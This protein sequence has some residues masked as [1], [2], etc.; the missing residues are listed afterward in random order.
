MLFLDGIYVVTPTPGN[1]PRFH[2]VFAPNSPYRARLPAAL[3]PA[4]S[5][6]ARARSARWPGK[7]CFTRLDWLGQG[8]FRQNLGF[9]A[10][11]DFGNDVEG[12][13]VA[14]EPGLE[15]RSVR[16]WVEAA[17]R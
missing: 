4:R 1:R 5:G 15:C 9:G 12:H 7:R 8:E 3:H 2:G 13:G 11:F 10:A 14:A 16:E 6:V 17:A